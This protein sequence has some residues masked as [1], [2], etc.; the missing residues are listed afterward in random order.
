MKNKKILGRKMIK[1][2]SRRGYRG[3]RRRN[4]SAESV[5]E[6][7]RCNEKS[8]TFTGTGVSFPNSDMVALASC[9]ENAP[10]QLNFPDPTKC[11]PQ[12]QL[13][14]LR[15]MAPRAAHL[16][17]NNFQASILDAWSPNSS[18]SFNTRE[19]QVEETSL[20]D[21]QIR[22]CRPWIS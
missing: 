11:L 19:I 21:F 22:R 18:S 8:R 10:P 12:A 20:I 7:G 3:M 4:E 6:V 5:S 1:E 2:T 13:T 9:G 17:A 14:S 15:D 16:A